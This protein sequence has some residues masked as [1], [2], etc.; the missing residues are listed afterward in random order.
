MGEDGLV[1]LR[2]DYENKWLRSLVLNHDRKEVIDESRGRIIRRFEP[3]YMNATS[4]YGRAHFYA[5]FKRIGNIEIDTWLFNMI[6]IWIGSVALFLVLY[7][8]LIRKLLE[9]IENLRLPKSE[10]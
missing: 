8:N 2:D 5:P 1:D 4:R 9:Y 7:Y 6:V 3:A 10:I